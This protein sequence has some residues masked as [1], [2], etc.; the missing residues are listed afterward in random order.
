AALAGGVAAFEDDHDLE[1]LQ[2]HPLLQLDQLELQ[3]DQLV[4]VFVFGR[5]PL[6]RLAVPDD[7][8]ALLDDLVLDGVLQQLTARLVFSLLLAGHCR[9]PL[10][11]LLLH[12]CRHLAKSCR[13]ATS[14]RCGAELRSRRVSMEWASVNRASRTSRR[15][16][17]RRVDF[18]SGRRR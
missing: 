4:D 5:R 7:A 10:L 1:A 9:A 6:R 13:I 17:A 12:R 15:M 11:S 2:P 18:T 16:R 3:A 14:V 8:P